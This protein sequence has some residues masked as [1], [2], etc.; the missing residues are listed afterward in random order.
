V[1]KCLPENLLEFAEYFCWKSTGIFLHWNYIHRV[2]DFE[3]A[4]YY[5]L[6]ANNDAA[7]P[8]VYW[9]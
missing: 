9:H 3:R 7:E 8:T 6:G 1:N 5:G 4:G 2:W